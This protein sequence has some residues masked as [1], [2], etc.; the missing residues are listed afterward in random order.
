MKGFPFGL[1]Q[2]PT[3]AFAASS[4][5]PAPLGIW[6]SCSASIPARYMENRKSPPC[7]QVAFSKQSSFGQALQ[8]A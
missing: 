4:S 3:P 6:C 1:A 2:E 7:P 8:V 5:A